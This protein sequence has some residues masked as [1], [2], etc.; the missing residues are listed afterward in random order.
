MKVIT[1]IQ[2]RELADQR[3]TFEQKRGLANDLALLGRIS[4]R[5]KPDAEVGMAIQ[6]AVSRIRKELRHDSRPL[7]AT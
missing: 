2:I 7:G 1:A 5:S 4:N 3:L 6:D